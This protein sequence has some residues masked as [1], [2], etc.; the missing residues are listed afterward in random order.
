M[1][2]VAAKL[3]KIPN[4]WQYPGGKKYY[5]RTARKKAIAQGH[6]KERAARKLV[7]STLKAR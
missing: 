4:G 3:I 7:D 2:S 6:A 1:S 5:G